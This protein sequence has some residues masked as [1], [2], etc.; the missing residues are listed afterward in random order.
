MIR[1][2]VRALRCVGCPLGPRAD[3]RAREAREMDGERERSR[4]VRP[5]AMA[6]AGRDPPPSLTPPPITVT[7]PPS[8]GVTVG[9]GAVVAFGVVED[10]SLGVD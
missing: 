7:L 8:Y 3:V 4:P 1:R 6:E 10:S 2:R 5:N 9:I